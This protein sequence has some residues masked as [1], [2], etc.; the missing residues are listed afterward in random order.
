MLTSH[1][2]PLLLHAL[3]QLTPVHPLHT[4]LPMCPFTNTQR[5]PLP[6]SPIHVQ[7]G[8][9]NDACLAPLNET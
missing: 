1:P 6:P 4:H 8:R 7:V 9:G 5:V 2:Y 3:P